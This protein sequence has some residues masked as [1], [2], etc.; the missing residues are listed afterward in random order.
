MSVEVGTGGDQ[1][2]PPNSRPVREPNLS[3]KRLVVTPRTDPTGTPVLDICDEGA[4]ES[5][6]L[7]RWTVDPLSYQELIEAKAGKPT[8][9]NLNDVVVMDSAGVKVHGDD[10]IAAMKLDCPFSSDVFAL[11]DGGWVPSS[12]SLGPGRILMADRCFVDALYSRFKD[13]KK[14][15]ADADSEFLDF[16]MDWPVTIN[17]LLYVMEGNTRTRPLATEAGEQFEEV[18]RKIS[19]ALPKATIMPDSQIGLEA[20]LNILD[21]L[22]RPYR[23]KLGFLVDVAPALMAPV[24]QCDRLR[25][26]NWIMEKADHHG[27]KRLSL[28]VLAAFS[29]ILLP[30]RTNPAKKLLKPSHVYGEKEAH[31]ALS[32][33]RA[34]EMLIAVHGQFPSAHASLWTKDRNMAL[35]WVGME[36][37]NSELIGTQRRFNIKLQSPLLAGATERERALLR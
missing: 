10:V 32:D 4:K 18:K 21:E 16:I 9:L 17:P 6:R 28:P 12:W 31:N 23:R 34:L 3:F 5:Y 35:F 24:A 14:R 22:E 26:L 27:V 25:K 30:A 1:A 37:V 29:S 36:I 13:G 20:A 15:R 11:V 19:S 33:L 8:T 7:A 2:I